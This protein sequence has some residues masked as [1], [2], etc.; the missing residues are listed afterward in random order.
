VSQQKEKKITSLGRIFDYL[1]TA[2]SKKGKFLIRAARY[3]IELL[4]GQGC[5][6]LKSRGG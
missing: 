2:L 3:V 4:N 6:K 1:V 5:P